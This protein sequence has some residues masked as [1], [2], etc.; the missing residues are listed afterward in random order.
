MGTPGVKLTDE[1]LRIA[2]E[3][4]YME[5]ASWPVTAEAAG[6]AESTIR[7][8]EYDQD[9]RWLTAI[10]D[11]VA[12]QKQRG[13]PVAY[14]CLVDQAEGGDVTAAKALIDRCEGPVPQ[15]IEGDLDITAKLNGNLYIAP[16]DGR[17]DGGGAP[18]GH[19]DP[20]DDGPAPLPGEPGT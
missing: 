12:V 11:V 4:R 17:P 3:Q 7:Q 14:K 10:G 5:R 9:A 18:A 13:L 19:A 1:Q 15:R 2:A 16:F 6:C 20:G 8:Y